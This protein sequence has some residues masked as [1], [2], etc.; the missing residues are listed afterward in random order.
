MDLADR[1]V[2]EIAWAAGL[3][4]GEGSISLSRNQ[5]RLKLGM[6]D[7][8]VVQRFA[9]IAGCGR[10]YVREEMRRVHWKPCWYWEVARRADCVAVMAALLPYLGERRTERWLEVCAERR[11]ADPTEQQCPQCQAT[12]MPCRRGTVCCSNE[13][14][15]RYSKSKGGRY[16]TRRRPPSGLR[17]PRRLDHNE[18]VR[19]S[20]EEGLSRQE[21]AERL[22]VSRQAIYHH[23][24]TENGR[25]RRA[26]VGLAP[27]AA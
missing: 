3:F 23:L 25:R 21:I 22:G 8:D 19:L 24:P 2:S 26:H 16:T 12:F 6:T 4:E 14:A 20:R 17:R 5:I 1:P 13:C 7:G 18:V 9:D 11:A 27:F 15:G 10:V